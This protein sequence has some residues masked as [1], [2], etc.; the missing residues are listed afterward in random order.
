MDRERPYVVTP[1]N[2]VDDLDDVLTIEAS[3]F[4]NPWTRSMFI[5]T[6]DRSPESQIFAARLLDGSITSYCVRQLVIDGLHIHILAVHQR[7]RG[8]GLG[9]YLLR[10]V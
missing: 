2:R 8:I 5:Q 1:M 4:T 3:S 6:L 9:G 7:W 10:W